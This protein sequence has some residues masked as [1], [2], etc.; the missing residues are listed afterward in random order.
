MYKEVVMNRNEQTKDL[1]LYQSLTAQIRYHKYL[2]Y[3]LGAQVISDKEYDVLEKRFDVIAD[4][5]K[6]PGSWV[7]CR[8]E[9][10]GL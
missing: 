7:D 1:L 8:D 6:W 2:Y 9:A 3:K 4:K 5:Y 10:D